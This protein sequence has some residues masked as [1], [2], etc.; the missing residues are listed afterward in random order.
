MLHRKHEYLLSDFKNMVIKQL[1]LNKKIFFWGGGATLSPLKWR[2]AGKWAPHDYPWP[3]LFHFKIHSNYQKEDV[4]KKTRPKNI[5]FWA[6]G[7]H[8][9]QRAFFGLRLNNFWKSHISL[10]F[11]NFYLNFCMWSLIIP[12]NKLSIAI[13]GQIWLL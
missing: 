8:F 3:P 2:Q 7:E 5:N 12:I 6:N 13:M 11:W 4:Y 10:N 9:V 1:L